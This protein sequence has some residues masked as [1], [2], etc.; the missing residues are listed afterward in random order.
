MIEFRKPVE[1]ASRRHIRLS[2][3]SGASV[4]PGAAG[5]TRRTAPSTRTGRPSFRTAAQASRPG[6]W[7][8]D[9]GRCLSR[10]IRTPRR[11]ADTARHTL[12]RYGRSREIR[13]ANHLLLI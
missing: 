8:T 4:R 6:A 10:Y 13:D 9:V 12:L 5:L 11:I 2:P 7:D 3:L 1:E